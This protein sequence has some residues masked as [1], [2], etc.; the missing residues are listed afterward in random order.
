MRKTT[1]VTFLQRKTEREI[2]G[3]GGGEGKKNG[4]IRVSKDNV[5][6]RTRRKT[7]KLLLLLLL[8]R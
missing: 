2:G 6:A 1:L 4:S 8:L 5:R 3:A 7:G